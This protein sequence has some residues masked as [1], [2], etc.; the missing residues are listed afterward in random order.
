[1]PNFNSGK[2]AT[3][4]RALKIGTIVETDKVAVTGQAQSDTLTM[5]T[6]PKDAV[7][8]SIQVSSSMVPFAT[9]HTLQFG[10]SGT[11]AKF[12]AVSTG[13]AAVNAALVS[14]DVTP[15]AADTP[16]IITIS[17]ASGAANAGDIRIAV[18]YDLHAITG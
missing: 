10:V 15:L 7:V 5:L 9:S 6:L 16:L 14:A 2:V 12:G 8:R 3:V 17:A 13:A 11:A 18:T 1:M 4:G